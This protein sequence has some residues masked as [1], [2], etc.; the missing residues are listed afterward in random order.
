LKIGVTVEYFSLDGKSPNSRDLLKMYDRGELM[1][2][3]RHL[4]ILVEISSYACA[5]F[6]FSDFIVLS[7]ST[8]DGYLNLVLG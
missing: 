8:V 2:G 7:I 4:R 1:K 3:A 5:F 6:V